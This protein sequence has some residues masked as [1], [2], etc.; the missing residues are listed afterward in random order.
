[1][2]QIGSATTRLTVS[3][4]AV[5][6]PSSTRAQM[7]CPPSPNYYHPA[8]RVF[9]Q[10]VKSRARALSWQRA[11][12]QRELARGR[13]A[14]IGGLTRRCHRRALRHVSRRLV[15][16]HSQL[17]GSSAQERKDPLPWPGQCRQDDA[18][19]HAEGRAPDAEQADAAP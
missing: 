6:R 2:A 16:L 9:A 18:A 3:S 19:A 14:P 8:S 12:P 11:L 13:H 4:M 7:I 17:A 5:P 10:S 15:L 1:M